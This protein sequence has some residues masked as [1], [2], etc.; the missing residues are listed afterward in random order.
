MSGPNATRHYLPVCS[1][2]C[3]RSTGQRRVINTHTQLAFLFN[4]SMYVLSV[5]EL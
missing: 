5:K 3:R 1:K 2:C 4:W